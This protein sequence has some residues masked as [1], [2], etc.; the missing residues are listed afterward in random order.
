MSIMFVL[1]IVRPDEN[2]PIIF[3]NCPD[4]EI[5]DKYAGVTK[6]ANKYAHRIL[7]FHLEFSLDNQSIISQKRIQ[8]TIETVCIFKFN[9]I[10][11]LFW[12][13]S[14]VWILAV[15][16]FIRSPPS[17]TDKRHIYKFI[18]TVRSEFPNTPSADKRQYLNVISYYVV[19]WPT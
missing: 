5:M 4:G 12:K 14:L 3:R 2:D 13:F 8:I 19:G 16:F 7:V 11:D 17:H 1:I 9:K 6:G 15:N 18:P 10:E